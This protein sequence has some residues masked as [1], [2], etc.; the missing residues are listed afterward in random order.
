MTAST[1]NL[2]DFFY[3]TLAGVAIGASMLLTCAVSQLP[4]GADRGEFMV[5]GLGAVLTVLASALVL[6]AAY[7]SGFSKALSIAASEPNRCVTA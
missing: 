5:F 4:E 1:K 2:G 3:R 6:R 7:A